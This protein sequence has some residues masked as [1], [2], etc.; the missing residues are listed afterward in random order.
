MPIEIIVEN[1]KSRVICSLKT[2]IALRES[3]KIKAKGY[4]FSPA[5]RSRRWDGYIR[6]ISE[7]NGMFSTGLLDQ[8]GD[9][10]KKMGKEF[11]VTDNRRLFKPVR[12]LKSI[13]DKKLFKHQLEAVK[14]LFSNKIYGIPFHRGIMGE[15]TN[16]GKSI[17]VATIFGSLSSKRTGVILVNNKTL[18]EQ[19]LKDLRELFPDETGQ[20]NSKIF[21]WKRIN[22]CMVQTLG[23]RLKKFPQYRNALSKVDVV[24]LDEGDEL[25]GRK[26][27]RSILSYCYNAPIRLIMTG[28]S[29]KHKGRIKDLKSGAVHGGSTKNQDQLA[30][31]GP[32]IHSIRNRQLVD[33]K[34]STPPDIR[35]YK[36]NTHIREN[37]DYKLEY[38]KGIMRNKK[39][40]RKIWKLV[41]KFVELNKVPIII[42]F[43]EHQQGYS[44]LR[45]CPADLKDMLKISLV[46]HKTASRTQI[47]EDFNNGLTDVLISSMIIKR[48]KNLPLI[49]VL[50]NAAGGDSETNIL[51]IFGRALRSHKSKKKVIIIDFWDMGCYLQRHS[52]HRVKYYKD[53]DF[54][55]K[56]LYK[57]K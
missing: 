13:G 24:I 21:D 18:Y 51:Q 3:I 2:L 53:Q 56:E 6:Y 44:L 10:L 52:K 5:Y 27:C 20:V 49:K 36:G 34:I 41:R 26:D 48:G 23:I 4:F 17:I 57:N 30:Y 25:I 28:T 54:P 12:V 43:K 16:A 40:H 9:A 1:N 33:E 42:L 37:G 15:A 39:R 19:T 14:A 29:L 31:A 7:V 45:N 50:I 46:H 47:L 55:V 8:V 32:I 22:V 11:F 35:I 38:K